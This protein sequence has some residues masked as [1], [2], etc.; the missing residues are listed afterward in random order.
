MVGY[1][2]HESVPRV[3]LTGAAALPTNATLHLS[4]F[5][6]PV[7]LTVTSVTHATNGNTTSGVTLGKFGLY[8]MNMDTNGFTLLRST[9]NRTS[10]SAN[11]INTASWS[12]GIIVLDPEKVYAI[13]ALF[14]STGNYPGLLT[15]AAANSINF[16]VYRAAPRIMWTYIQTTGSYTDLP[17][18][19]TGSTLS[20]GNAAD[21]YNWAALS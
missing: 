16:T 14:S 12:E 8:E 5:T 2:I 17:S 15:C 7:P 21:R 6:V 4:G 13:G 3:Q 19:E 20:T 10:W 11:L 9:A 1:E 18:S